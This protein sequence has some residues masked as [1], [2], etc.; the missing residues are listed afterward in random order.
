MSDGTTRVSDCLTPETARLLA[1]LHPSMFTP[2]ML[3]Q[4]RNPVFDQSEQFT[5]D[6]YRGVA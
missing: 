2:E 1:K 6:L 5:K 3:E 4:V